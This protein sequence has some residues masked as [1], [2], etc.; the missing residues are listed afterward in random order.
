MIHSCLPVYFQWWHIPVVFFAGMIGEAYGCIVGG[1]GIV[2]LAAQISIGVPIKSAIATGTTGALGTEAGVI[3]ETHQQI[4]ANKK[5]TLQIAIPYTL[6]GIVG[7]WLLLHV[8][9]AIIKN[10]M[11]AAV[12]IVLVHAF[13][14]NGKKMTKHITKS[15]H[16]LLFTFMFL[17]SVYGSL[18]PGE[19]AFSKFA[20]MSVLGLTFLQSQGLKS[21]AT[22]PSRLYAMVVTTLAGLVIWP[23]AI[24][25]WV[26]TFIGSKYATKVAKKIP[27]KY[28]KALLAVVS[29]AF[30][31]Y[32]LFFYGHQS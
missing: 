11:I 2:I 30:V 15:Q 24:T 21:A 10:F 9:P 1:G 17:S 22:V 19:G 20:L 13:Y 4:T 26:S 32:L 31:L 16:V 8:S 14:S 12:V 29:V 7:V 28:L 6:G 3:S 27:D 18:A 23:Y 5:L 25:L